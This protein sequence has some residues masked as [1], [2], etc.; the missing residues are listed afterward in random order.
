M[1][2]QVCA[3]YEK[4]VFN[5]PMCVAKGHKHNYKF[6]NLYQDNPDKYLVSLLRTTEEQ[7]IG[8]IVITGE[9]DPTQNMRFVKDIIAFGQENHIITELQTH[10]YNVNV[11]ELFGLDVLSYSITNVK[12]YLRAHKFGKINGINRLVILLTK[13]FDFLNKDNFNPMG[14]KQITFKTLQ[15]GED[16]Q[17]NKWI[18]ENKLQDLSKIYEIVDHY[19][20]TDTS[21]RIDTSCQTAKGRYFVFRSDGQL[22]ESWEAQNPSYIRKE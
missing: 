21:V 7:D 10:N 19:N 11:G 22:Y 2:L 8:N 13:E 18:D 14:F 5:C 3:P 9:C 12:G 15:H 6:K 16:E 1:N 4:C 20:G 17:I